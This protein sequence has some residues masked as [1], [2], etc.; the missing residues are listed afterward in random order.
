MINL[1]PCAQSVSISNE[2]ATVTNRLQLIE[3]GILGKVL[4]KEV[5]DVGMVRFVY[6]IHIVYSVL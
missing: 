3:T 4:I 1:Q 5:L 2:L 6:R